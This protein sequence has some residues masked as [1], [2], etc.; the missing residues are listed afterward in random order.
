MMLDF[1]GVKLQTTSAEQKIQLLQDI[2][3]ELIG[4]QDLKK[5][6]YNKGLI[7]TLTPMLK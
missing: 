5:A 7:E 6:Y 3:N 1:E 2:K 4:C